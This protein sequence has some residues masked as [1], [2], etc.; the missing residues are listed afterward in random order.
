V[1]SVDLDGFKAIN[2]SLGHAVGDDL[3]RSLSQRIEA[4]L[5]KGDS[6]ARFA[7]DQFAILL[8]QLGN[9]VDAA[10]LARKLIAEIAEPLSLPSHRVTTRCS[11][12]IATFPRDSHDPEELLEKAATAAFH[13]KRAGG[14]RFAYFSEPM[15]AAVQQRNALAERLRTAFDDDGFVLHYQPQYDLTRARIVG[16]EA[17][18]RWRHPELGLLL[19]SEFLPVV[20]QAGLTGRIGEWTLRTACAQ[21][22]SWSRA[23]HRGLRVSVNIA[24]TQFLAPSMV[25]LV[26]SA[27]AATGVAVGS[28]ELEITENS[29]VHDVNTAVETIHALKELGV[30]LAIDDFGTGYSSL[31]YLKQLPIDV[32]KIDQSFV[33]SLTSDP[34]DATITEAIIKLASGL[35]LLTIAEGVETFEQLLMLGSFGCKRMQGYLFGKPAPPE[36]FVEWLDDPPFRWTRGEEDGG[37]RSAPNGPERPPQSRSA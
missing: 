7:G 13:A 9:E 31:A 29:L 3:L 26:R 30:R 19:P 5:R 14:G 32:L 12:G 24:P 8:T 15:N 21:L 28:L 37:E 20:E 33:R 25:D 18:I 23:G 34:A 27:L 4:C 22:A 36:S 35:N 11:I 2:D 1:L 10:Q 16:A 6:A 17:L